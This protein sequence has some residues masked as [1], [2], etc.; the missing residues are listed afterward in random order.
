MSKG[1]II[2]NR[3]IIKIE[4][5]GKGL[6]SKV[7]IVEDKETKK[8][9]AVKILKDKFYEQNFDI[10]KE[11]LQLLKDKKIPNVINLISSGEFCTEKYLILDLAQKGH[12]YNVI[13]VRPLTNLYLI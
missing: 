8:Y 12:L 11:V 9:Y 7:S 4:N 2:E 13:N 3:Y 1:D 10:E 5:I 6:T